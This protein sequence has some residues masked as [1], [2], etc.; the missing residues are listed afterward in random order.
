MISVSRFGF[1]FKSFVFDSGLHGLLI[2]HC[3]VLRV[4]VFRESTFSKV[5]VGV[6]LDSKDGTRL[7]IIS[8]CLCFLDSKGLAE[9][10]H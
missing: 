6:G 1:C 5:L 2:L 3:I 9:A 10:N 8:A 4:W 7:I